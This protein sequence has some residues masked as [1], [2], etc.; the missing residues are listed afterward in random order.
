[1]FCQGA[2]VTL[3]APAGYASYQWGDGS[4]GSVLEASAAGQYS[5]TVTDNNGCIGVGSFDVTAN[6]LPG[7]EIIGGLSYCYGQSTLLVAPAG[8]ASYLWNDGST[9]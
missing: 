1:A 3:Q 9:A 4:Q 8:Y 2:S 5:Y 7:F 6:A